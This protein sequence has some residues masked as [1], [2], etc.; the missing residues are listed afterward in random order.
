MSEIVVLLETFRS[1]SWVVLGVVFAASMGLLLFDR[2]PRKD[3]G[4][5]KTAGPPLR[6]AA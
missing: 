1:F 3:I 4:S 6:R 5:E 2:T